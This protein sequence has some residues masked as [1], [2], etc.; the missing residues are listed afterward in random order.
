M[1]ATGFIDVVICTYNRA[2]L[3]DR[4]LA[5]LARQRN[6]EAVAWSVLVV[7]N[8]ST[9]ATAAVVDAHVRAGRV[10][11]LRIEREPEQGLTPARRHGVLATAAPWIAFVDD[12]CVLAEDWIAQA[13]AFLH[14]H[15]ETGGMGGRVE[16]DWEGT[17]PGYVHG[18][19]WALAAQDHGAEAKRVA[20]LAGAGM[21]IRREA[22]RACGW[23]ARPL[24][25]DRVG[26]RLV[27]GGDV[28]LT[29]RVRGAGYALWYNPACVLQHV[30]DAERTSRRYLVRLIRGLGVSQTL[31]DALVWDEGYGEWREATHQAVRLRAFETARGLGRAI[32][33]RRALIPALF[34]AS[35]VWGQ[36]RGV[37]QVERMT[38]ARREHLLGC[39]APAHTSPAE[40]V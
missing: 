38:E 6:A 28:E 1:S 35:F 8:N 37:R 19:G 14:T 7:D 15:P 23:L 30:V 9:D 32:R 27:S 36:W 33:H 26:K 29:L 2:P 21:V 18:Y 31:A 25:D 4:A 13:A 22:L 40:T 12:D 5:A 20:S 10:P 39:A 16:L 17:P 3:L 34:D 24:L 11:G